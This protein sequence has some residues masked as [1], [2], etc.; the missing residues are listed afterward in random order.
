MIREGDTEDAAADR[1]GKHVQELLY[2]RGYVPP[3]PVLRFRWSRS[4]WNG[5]IRREHKPVTI[6]YFLTLFSFVFFLFA[7]G[8]GGWRCSK[9]CLCTVIRFF[10]FSFFFLQ[11]AGMPTSPQQAKP[12]L[13]FSVLSQEKIGIRSCMTAW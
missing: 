6:A 12:S 1:G 8:A 2:H 10:S 7:K 11:M 9:S 4:L 3:A 5:Q 13:F